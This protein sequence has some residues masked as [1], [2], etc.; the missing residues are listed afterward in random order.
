MKKPRAP[1]LLLQG[2]RRGS[3]LSPSSGAPDGSGEGVLVQ[4][5]PMMP[6]ICNKLMKM[7]KML[8]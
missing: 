1:S 7:L 4:S 6:R 5:S 2:R 3:S 8:R